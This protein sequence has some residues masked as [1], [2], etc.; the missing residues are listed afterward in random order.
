MPDLM[1]LSYGVCLRLV[2]E[3][4]NDLF[5]RLRAALPP[6]VAVDAPEATVPALTLRIG[7][8][9]DG[10][11]VVDGGP[12]S[13]RPDDDGDALLN[14]ILQEI[15][16]A[17]SRRSRQCLFV[18]A[19]VV[20]WRGR[21]IVMPGRS[22]AGKS[23]LAAAL[24]R[25]GAVYYSDEYAIF[26]DTGRV[27]PYRRALVLRDEAARK[28]ALGL[29]L[30]R[31]SEPA[32]PLPV[33]LVVST[34]H[35]VGASWRPGIVRG[36][37]VALPL[38]DNTVLAREEHART[39]QIAAR[40]AD[41][42]LLLQGV[43]GEADEVAARLLDV[44]DT[45]S[46]SQALRPGPAARR[47]ADDAAP[48]AAARLAAKTLPPLPPN[49]GLW[50]VPHVVVPDLLSPDEHQR[51]LDF[52]L[53]RADGFQESRVTTAGRGG[54]VDPDYRSSRTFLGDGFEPLW[55]VFEPRLRAMLPAVRDALGIPWFR[56]GTIERQ[57]TVH[58]NGGFFA[59]HS[60]TGSAETVSRKISCVYY[61]HAQP[62]RYSGGKLKL[63]DLW[64]MPSGTTP[65]GT[66]TEIEP[67]DN[68]VVF[69]RSE[70]FHEVAAV[71]TDA[72]GFDCG[73]FTVVIWFREAAAQP[74]LQAQPVSAEA[75]A[76]QA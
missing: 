1:L 31:P 22:L 55:A 33:G 56:V 23:T 7:R 72:P 74:A 26:D 38:I 18:H 12:Q 3:L 75:V 70:D 15:D 9:D 47:F 29:R 66:Y 30:V 13:R 24:V 19:A 28:A 39:L 32:D 27:H 5:A 41:E 48:V 40:V 64:A 50:M 60:D 25:R 44:L 6:E 11:I 73:R 65:A 51:L 52:A 20:G 67:R 69:F 37:R 46:A 14:C 21:A 76:E 35:Q 68:S 16:Q 17:L 61:F 49:R 54:R 58:H 4:D 45:V 2:D 57:L 10:G 53:A 42:A 63:F 62:Q 36:A 71:H 43:R 8:A 34:S 59:P